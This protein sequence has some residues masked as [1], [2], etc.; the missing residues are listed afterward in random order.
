MTDRNLERL[1]THQKKNRGIK[2]TY[3]YEILQNILYATRMQYQSLAL[4][5]DQADHDFCDMITKILYLSPHN[6]I[7]H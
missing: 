6:E 5:N 7:K 3:N 1:R 4:R 2:G